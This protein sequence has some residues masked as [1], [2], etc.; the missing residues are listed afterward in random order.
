MMTESVI[1]DQGFTPEP[2]YS[3]RNVCF[4]HRSW[5]KVDATPEFEHTS[6]I[7]TQYLNQDTHQQM[8]CAT[9]LLPNTNMQHEM[10]HHVYDI[11]RS[12]TC[13]PNQ[14]EEWVLR[15]LRWA[16]EPYCSIKAPEIKFFVTQ[17]PNILFFTELTTPNTS[18]QQSSTAFRILMT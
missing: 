2:L 15:M 9:L 5:L 16:L 4:N 6:H 10:V 13:A 3:P 14:D 17:E 8:Q 11:T 12:T 1:Y 7:E 18:L